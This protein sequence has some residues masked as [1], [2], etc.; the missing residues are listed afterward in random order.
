MKKVNVLK[1]F[2]A[3]AAIAF[4]S[5]SLS[6]KGT[7]SINSYLKTN[8]AVVS[9]HNSELSNFRVKVIDEEG[10]ELYSSPNIKNTSA[11]Q[12]L[13]DLNS[14]KNGNYSVVIVSKGSKATETFRVENSTLVLT[15]ESLKPSIEKEET[16]SARLSP[17]F[18]KE[19]DNIYLSHLNFDN[20][21][22][23]ISIDDMR[24]NE[25]FNSS[26]PRESSYSGIFD[27]SRL[28]VGEYSVLIKSGKELY[29]YEFNK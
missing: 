29:R 7:V 5:A 2:L 27:I 22:F 15:E 23:S 25:I 1:G 12:K 20:S 3:I 17:F 14:F 16:E 10:T 21:L 11:F 24:G 13:F 18:R 28:P 6:A 26:L 9:A 4:C 19:G 8:Y